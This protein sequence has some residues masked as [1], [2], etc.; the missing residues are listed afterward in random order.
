ME[1]EISEDIVLKVKSFLHLEYIDNEYELYQKLVCELRKSHPDNFSDEEARKISEN[2]FKELNNLRDSFN[3]YLERKRASNQ[4][5]TNSDEKEIVS[6]NATNRYIDSELEK[7]ELQREIKYLNNQI[8]RLKSSID[9]KEK[10]IK[11]LLGTSKKQSR[12]NLSDI[13]KPK[14]IA[15]FTGAIT[16]VAT[17]SL[18]VP[19][20]QQLLSN[21]GI[22]GVIA[23]C[24][25]GL[26]EVLWILLWC[27]SWIIE[28]E[29]KL[30]I[31]KIITSST[32]MDDF[33]VKI[34]LNSYRDAVFSEA[35]IYKVVD[36]HLS[37]SYIKRLVYGS[38][39]SIKRNISEYVILEFEQKNIIKSSEVI[40]LMRIFRINYKKESEIID[41]I[42]LFKL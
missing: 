24:I 10:K 34:P 39:D 4:L 16:T 25:I 1:K 32:L 13:Y 28:K 35:N 14:K 31:D 3:A 33:E 8:N 12:T 38:C 15:N 22:G 11:E 27:R 21:A 40:N 19:K 18:F 37:S 20:V 9:E 17:L 29:S 23:T 36:R 7:I 26:I 6:F 2:R 42:D 5:V 30:I 41:N